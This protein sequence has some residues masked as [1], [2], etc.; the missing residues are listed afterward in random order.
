M[1]TT[2]VHVVAI[3]D[4]MAEAE[5]KAGM[6]RA[7]LRSLKDDFETIN[8]NGDAGFLATKKFFTQLDA[9]ASSFEA[10]LY[11]LHS[12]MTVYAQERG[13]DLPSPLSGG[14]R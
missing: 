9:A 3:A 12:D 8:Q 14:G 2:D 13:I 10:K 6:I 11:V 5:Q 4:A 1:A 7:K